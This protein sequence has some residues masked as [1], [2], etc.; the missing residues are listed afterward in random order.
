MR[1][2]LLN[3][4]VNRRFFMFGFIFR[5]CYCFAAFLSAMSIVSERVTGTWNRALAA[6]VSPYH[7][8]LSH[9]IEGLTI[10]MIQFV[11]FAAY[12]VIFLLPDQ[13]LST[14]VTISA[15]LFMSQL[16]GL[17]CGLLYSIVMK[18]AMASFMFTQF[19]VYPATFVSGKLI[20]D[21]K[22]QNY[23]NFFSM[24]FRCNLALKWNEHSSEKHRKSSSICI[25]D[26]R[27]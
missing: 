12:A 13:R 24:F 15:I 1:K 25:S 9:L 27:V 19:S 23:F 18:S 8:L 7:F 20:D 16:N 4:K 17:V 2:L 11:E 26:N 22:A 6:G 5:G 21:V 14:I 3:L 10:L